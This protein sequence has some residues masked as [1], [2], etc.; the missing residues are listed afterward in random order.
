MFDVCIITL[1]LNHDIVMLRAEKNGIWA[2]RDF[3]S[4]SCAKSGR[5]DSADVERE[6]AKSPL[7]FP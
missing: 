4:F 2:Y 7:R 3:M 1:S 5:E 6:Y